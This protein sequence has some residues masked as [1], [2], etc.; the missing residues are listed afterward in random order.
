MDQRVLYTHI[1]FRCLYSIIFHCTYIHTYIHS[2]LSTRNHP[3]PPW[4][5]GLH[6]AH[7]RLGH[8]PG[9]ALA[10]LERRTPGAG[11]SHGENWGNGDNLGLID[12]D[13]RGKTTHEGVLNSRIEMSDSRFE[14]CFMSYLG[15]EVP[16][17][18]L[19]TP[20]GSENDC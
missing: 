3:K 5:P 12:V 8:R 20:L 13:D 7:R 14:I 16:R 2:K 11:D 10:R 17:C 19:V 18:C 4:T 15:A 9:H 1:D 6:R